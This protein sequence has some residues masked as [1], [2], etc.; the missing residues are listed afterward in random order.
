MLLHLAEPGVRTDRIVDEPDRTVD[1]VLSYPMP[2]VTN[3]GVVGKPSTASAERGAEL[4]EQL[5]QALAELLRRARAER[6]PEL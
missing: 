2:A 1:R 6:D 4:V 5:V 3:S